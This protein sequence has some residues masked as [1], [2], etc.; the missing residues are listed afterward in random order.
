ME[1]FNNICKDYD[2]ELQCSAEVKSTGNDVIHF[3]VNKS[4][5][6][7]YF[8]ML[9]EYLDKNPDKVNIKNKEGYTPLILASIFSNGGSSLKTVDF[10]LERG[11]NINLK[12]N[13]G[14]TA[15]MHVS[16]NSKFSSNKTV[17]F[18]L[19]RGANPNLQDKNGHTA[20]MMASGD[21]NTSSTLETVKT[22]L[23]YG[24]DPNLHNNFGW[25][26]LSISSLTFDA[27]STFETVEILLE[28]GAD[29]NLQNNDGISALMRIESYS[30]VDDFNKVLK[31]LRKY[32]TN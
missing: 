5:K 7:N 30:D 20:L 29:P 22:L 18:L 3:L 14:M 6:N 4:R 13:D 19:E 31:L 15:L 8:N 2:L 25:T 10:L 26:A 32:N 1:F 11:A 24:A 16:Y 27:T 12:D 21:S 17:K 23:E 28:G 9:K